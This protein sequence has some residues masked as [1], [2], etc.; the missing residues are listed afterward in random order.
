M[1]RVST[2]L[3]ILV[4]G[5]STAQAGDISVHFR[6]LDLSNARDA[7]VLATRVQSAATFAC[8]V[9]KPQA[10][11]TSMFYRQSYEECLARAAHH[12]TAEAMASF[13]R[14]PRFASN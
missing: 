13:G 5:I 11:Q 10:G 6:D 7:G 2:T 14:T 3:A 4:L 1:F 8:A 12:L 9:E